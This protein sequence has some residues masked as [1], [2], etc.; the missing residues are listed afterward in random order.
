MNRNKKNGKKVKLRKM[1]IKKKRKEGNR[2][3]V[4]NGKGRETDR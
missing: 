4:R 1:E 3:K 2:S